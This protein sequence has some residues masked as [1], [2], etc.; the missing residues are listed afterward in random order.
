MKK[1]LSAILALTLILCAMPAALAAE[2]EAAVPTV[3]VST[4]TQ[5]IY[6]DAKD[7][8]DGLAPVKMNGKWGYI[9]ETGKTVIDFK[10]DYAGSFSEGVALVA[11]RETQK[12]SYL[13]RDTDRLD[14]RDYEAYYFYL[15]K[16]DG[17]T[18]VLP[19]FQSGRFCW[20]FCAC[21]RD[22]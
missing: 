14:Q 17:D 8:S 11:K 12:L 4:L 22:L 3:T 13:N 5:P 7:F 9:D 19:Q 21:R 6:E 15:L 16:R 2:E 18:S 10:Y 20:R 1:L